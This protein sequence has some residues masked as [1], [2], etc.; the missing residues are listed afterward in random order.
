MSN[1]SFDSIILVDDRDL[2][3]R[4]R[5]IGAL[6]PSVGLGA[7]FEH[8][9]SALANASP[10][11]VSYAAHEKELDELRDELESEIKDLK[12]EVLNLEKEKDKLESTLDAIDDYGGAGSYILEL[13]SQEKTWREKAAAWQRAYEDLQSSVNKPTRRKCP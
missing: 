10:D 7:L 12:T 13:Q 4:G 11:S 9:E 5:H 2:Y 1:S 8:I 3:L 6:L